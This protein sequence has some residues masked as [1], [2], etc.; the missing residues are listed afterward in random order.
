VHANETLDD[1]YMS[2]M[3]SSDS[4][5]AL[6]EQYVALANQWGLKVTAYEAGPGWNVGNNA[7]LGTVILAQRFYQMRKVVK[8][9]LET[10]W[11]PSGAA[12][13]N[14]FAATG[15]YSRYGQWGSTEHYFNLTT[16]KMC[17]IL[18]L[19]SPPGTLPK[20]CAGW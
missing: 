10:S 4:Q 19:V 15:L 7:D 1:I 18:D 3:N 9:D 16:P 5:T 12:E 20:G 14:Y 2:Y 11:V 8:Y 6:R 13:Y 17:G